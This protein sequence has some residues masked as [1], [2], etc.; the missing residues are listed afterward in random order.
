MGN[1]WDKREDEPAF[2]YNRFYEWMM[3]GPERTFDGAYRLVRQKAAKPI[4]GKGEANAGWRRCAERWNW[5]ARADAYD[6]EQRVARDEEWERRREDIRERDYKLGRKLRERIE[7]MVDQID[8]F[9]YTRDEVIPDPAKPGEFMT[10]RVVGLQAGPAE[11]ARV[12][13]DASEMERR[14][15]NMP[16]VIQDVTSGGQPIQAGEVVFVMERNGTEAE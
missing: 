12:I 11:I 1:A 7:Q 4:K 10:L 16:S 5:K 3:M 9:F 8:R 6:T 15:A 2:W 14:G 13:K